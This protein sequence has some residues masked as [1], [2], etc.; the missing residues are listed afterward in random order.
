MGAQPLWARAGAA[1]A[2]AASAGALVFVRE[3]VGRKK[4]SREMEPKSA[5][6]QGGWRAQLHLTKYFFPS[7]L[8]CL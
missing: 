3:S 2:A 8:P 5:S 4:E 1:P 7:E 6:F